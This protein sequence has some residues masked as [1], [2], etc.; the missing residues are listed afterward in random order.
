MRLTPQQDTYTSTYNKT[1]TAGGSS[2]T[3]RVDNVG[4]ETSFL[5]F[6]MSA[7]A[8]KTITSATLRL[9]TS[10][11]A[12]ATSSGTFDVKLVAL[13]DWQEQWMSYSNTVA[14]S[15]TVLGT[16]GAPSATNTW[17]QSTLSPSVV[18]TRAGNLISM[19]I[20][21]RVNDV[22]IVNSKESTSPPELVVTYK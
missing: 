12:W 14:I 16:L 18:Q 13:N 4:V 6:D 15:S 3:L 1:S 20:T 9:H 5:R 8:G 22:L 17:Y 21:G 2:A 7:L 11:E 19:A 10:S